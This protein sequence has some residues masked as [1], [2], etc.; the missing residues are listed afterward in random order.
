MMLSDDYKKGT[1]ITDSVRDYL[2]KMKRVLASPKH[3]NFLYE[4][5]YYSKEEYLYII[6]NLVDIPMEYLDI[7]ALY[8]NLCYYKKN[9]LVPKENVKVKVK[10]EKKKMPNR[11]KKDN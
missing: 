6:S 11:Y 10:E 2:I 5:K 1:P 3:E 4:G 7:S 9:G 8:L